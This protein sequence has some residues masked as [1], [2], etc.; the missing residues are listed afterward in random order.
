MIKPGFN[1]INDIY[2]RFVIETPSE[3]QLM[4]FNEQIFN[5]QQFEQKVDYITKHLA[6]LGVKQ[7]SVVG[8]SFPNNPES[9]PLFISIARLGACAVPLFHMIPDVAKVGIFALAR[10]QVIITTSQIAP[11]LKEQASKIQAN[12]K[13]ATIDSC[14]QADYSFETTDTSSVIIE[15]HILNDTDSNLPLLIASSSGT[16]GI[17]KIVIMTQG[18]VASEF[19]IAQELAIPL[20]EDN[21]VAVIAFPLS[22]AGVIVC[23]GTML[24][25]VCQVFSA[26]VSP[27]KFMELVSRWSPQNVV[28]P[29]A[30]FEAI[31]SLPDLNKY[32]LS[33]V[34]RM[35]GG[36]DFLTPSLVQRMKAKFTN[37]QGFANGYGLI[38]T[39]NVFMICKVTSENELLSSPTCKMEVACSANQIEVRD[40]NGNIVPIGTEGELYVKGANV[41][42]GYVNNVEESVASFKDGWFRTGDI[43]R[44]ESTTSVTL[45]GRKKYLIKR[46]G[47][48]VS[49]IVVQN[50]INTCEGVQNSA[51]VGIPHPLYGEMVWAFVV[52]HQGVNIEFKDVMKHC[53]AGLVNYMVPDQ[54]I[55]IDEIPK[56]P[57]VGKVSY[58]KLRE[59]A[60][61]EMKKIE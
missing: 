42:R 28:A 48:S 25:G 55:F 52:K 59:M 14:T 24:A 57:G 38:E 13:I 51:V 11:G 26:D 36:M 60:S 33:S 21:N 47:K 9:F 22:T 45:L 49:P 17:P 31:L 58:E 5:K 16:T 23:L 4:C 37:M 15:N 2:R 1:N 56:N 12:F 27:V 3:K 44:Y 61:I 34:K 8:Y 43:V 40:E 20:H 54:I 41:V 19:Y 18:N 35:M 30:Y 6:N 7:G 10:A 50:F 29:P 53:R 32:D 39:T 46:G